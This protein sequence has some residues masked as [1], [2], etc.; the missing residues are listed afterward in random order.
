MHAPWNDPVALDT[1]P[2]LPPDPMPQANI[3]ADSASMAL[4][5]VDRGAAQG[6][7]E[8]LRCAGCGQS[9]VVALGAPTACMQRCAARACDGCQRKFLPEAIRCTSNLVAAPSPPSDA[10]RMFLD[11]VDVHDTIP[12]RTGQRCAHHASCLS[13]RKAQRCAAC[14]AGVHTPLA[15]DVPIPSSPQ[16]PTSPPHPRPTPIPGRCSAPPGSCP[17]R[18][19]GRTGTGRAPS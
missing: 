9:L 7:T 11:R 17:Q 4:K 12:V 13:A 2:L 5:I 8:H 10:R 6:L 18:R 14:F 1:L 19:S 3:M 15:V 16:L